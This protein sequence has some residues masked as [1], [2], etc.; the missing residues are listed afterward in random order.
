MTTKSSGYYHNPT[1]IIA[2]DILSEFINF[3]KHFYLGC[4]KGPN[5]NVAKKPTRR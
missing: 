1:K 3:T 5:K 2:K 4:Q